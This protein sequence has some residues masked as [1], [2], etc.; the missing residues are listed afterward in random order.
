MY[1]HLITY[2]TLKNAISVAFTGDAKIIQFYDPNKQVNSVDEIVDDI[3]EKVKGHDDGNLQLHGVYEKG[4]T[5]GYFVFRGKLLISFSVNVK[6]RTRSY[7]K[8]FFQVIRYC[9]TGTFTC[10]LWSRN[11]R[12][13]KWLVKMGMEVCSHNELI[14]QLIYI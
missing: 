9:L 8:A 2:K 11:V 4:E 6:Y 3:Y 5:I 13:I 1:S 10:V 7:L 12:A 14:T